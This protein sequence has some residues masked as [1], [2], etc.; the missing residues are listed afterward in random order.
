MDYTVIY[1]GVEDYIGGLRDY[2]LYRVGEWDYRVGE[3]RN[4][5]IQHLNTSNPAISQWFYIHDMDIIICNGLRKEHGNLQ[6]FNPFYNRFPNSN[7][8]KFSEQSSA[9]KEL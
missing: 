9:S 6:S 5:V 7:A 4:I 2:I 8:R 1:I 3:G